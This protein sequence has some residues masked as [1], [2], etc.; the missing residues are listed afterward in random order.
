MFNHNKLVFIQRSPTL[1]ALLFFTLFSLL[2][3][4]VSFAIS[5]QEL[6]TAINKNDV[7]IKKEIKYDSF[8]PLPSYEESKLLLENGGELL[9]PNEFLQLVLN[10]GCTY[11]DDIEQTCNKLI[12]QQ[13]ILA[14]L[15]LQHGADL[16][17]NNFQKFP[18]VDLSEL[19]LNKGLD[20]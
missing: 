12:K 9:K 16:E 15:A 11:L 4:T 1:F 2:L 20:P 14:E 13:K 18:T 19:F 5:A 3:P 8:S 6:L 10:K 7:S 17:T